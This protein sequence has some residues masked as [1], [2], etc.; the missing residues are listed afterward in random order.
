MFINILCKVCRYM[1]IFIN[2]TLAKNVFTEMPKNS[3]LIRLT[4]H[5]FRKKTRLIY[6]NLH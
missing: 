5:R 1:Y 6:I 4:S 2:F 3:G